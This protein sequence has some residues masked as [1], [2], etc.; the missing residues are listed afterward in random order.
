MTLDEVKRTGTAPDERLRVA[1]AAAREAMAIYAAGGQTDDRI[2]AQLLVARV[3]EALGDGFGAFEAQLN[4]V[5]LSA[6]TADPARR[7]GAFRMLC[8]CTG[9]CRRSGNARARSC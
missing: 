6:Q 4:A 1:E 5:L 9:T 7:A 8:R 2:G 3:R